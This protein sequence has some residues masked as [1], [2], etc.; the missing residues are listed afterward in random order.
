MDTTNLWKEDTYTRIP[1]L[2]L[3]E[4]IKDRSLS[5]ASIRIKLFISRLTDGFESRRMTSYLSVTEM[6]EAIRMSLS[7]TS[8]ELKRLISERK[9]F[10]GDKR[11]RS[12]RYSNSDVFSS[13]LS[14][15]SSE[16]S[17]E[18]TKVSPQSTYVDPEE[19]SEGSKI[20][21]RESS[22]GSFS[23]G[24]GKSLNLSEVLNKGLNK[25]RKKEENVSSFSLNSK[26]QGQSQSLA[27]KHSLKEISD[28]TLRDLKDILGIEELTAYLLRRGHDE[29]EVKDRLQNL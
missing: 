11:G 12:Y 23:D 5:P 6:A 21:L 28:E 14:S 24:E 15:Q 7:Q 22:E 8:K 18:E 4:I 20:S 27:S 10:R 17:T 1:N 26:S 13:E 2:L 3:K 19:N 25:E 16:V 9:L 29:K